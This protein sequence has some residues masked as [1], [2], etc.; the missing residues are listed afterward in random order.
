MTEVV[1]STEDDPLLL[2]GTGCMMSIERA[3]VLD[4]FMMSLVFEFC[5]TNEKWR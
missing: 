1:L 2:L 3:I 5:E 4:F